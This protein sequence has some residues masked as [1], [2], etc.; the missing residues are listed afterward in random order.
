MKH[1]SHVHELAIAGTSK[2]HATAADCR[3]AT[4][5]TWVCS[6]MSGNSKVPWLIMGDHM[7]STFLRNG[8]G[9]WGQ[10]FAA[11]IDPLQRFFLSQK[12]CTNPSKTVGYGVFIPRQWTETILGCFLKSRTPQLQ[13]TTFFH[14]AGRY[15][16]ITGSS[17][18]AMWQRFNSRFIGKQCVALLNWVHFT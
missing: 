4:H 15:S 6:K 9:I 17:H 16:F 18:F 5:A 1:R 12:P 7:L 13:T 8:A 3:H 2:I 11:N 10:H 14:D